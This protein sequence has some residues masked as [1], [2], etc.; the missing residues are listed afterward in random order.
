MERFEPSKTYMSLQREY[1]DLRVVDESHVGPNG[2]T[3]LAI[4]RNEMFFLPAFLAHYRGLGVQR[5][6]FLDDRSDDGSFEYLQR[7]TDTVIVKSSRRFGDRLDLPPSISRT[8]KDPR[9]DFL[10]RSILYNMFA[11]DRWALLVDLDEFIHLP[12]GMTFQYLIS[13]LN[14]HAIRALSA[15]MLDVYPKDIATFTENET[16][17]QLDTSATWYFDGEQ[18]FRLRKGPAHQ[19]W[20]TQERARGSTASMESISYTPF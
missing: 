10:W 19:R 20:S 7:Q 12:R 15:V 4:L 1:N 2:F 11:Q 14:N 18:H 17:T 3:L 5:F 6:V 9:M 8:N 16:S 13:Q